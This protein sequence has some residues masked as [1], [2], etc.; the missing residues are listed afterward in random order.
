MP[1][2]H[3][4]VYKKKLNTFYKTENATMMLMTIIHV[5]VYRTCISDIFPWDAIKLIV[6]QVYKSNNIMY[7]S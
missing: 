6:S 3:I 7:S 5:H 4:H 2:V 1:N